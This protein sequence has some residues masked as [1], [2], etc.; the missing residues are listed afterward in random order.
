MAD[1]ANG[2]KKK[3]RL[4]RIETALE[5]LANEH[6]QLLKAQVLIHDAVLKLAEAQ[7]AS[8]KHLTQLTEWHAELAESQAELARAQAR[9][10]DAQS[11]TD[12]KMAELFET[13]KHTDERMAALIAIVDDLIRRQP[14]RQSPN[15]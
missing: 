15:Q 14:P 1:R 11:L 13:Q 5:A 6:Q 3:D 2:N 8:S 12:R 4:D 9:S 10:A 7:T